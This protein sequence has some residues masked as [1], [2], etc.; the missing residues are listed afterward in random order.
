[1]PDLKRGEP[2]FKAR[3]TGASPDLPYEPTGNALLDAVGPGAYALRK[4]VA[5]LDLHGQPVLRP[6]RAMKDYGVSDKDPDPRGMTVTGAD[7]KSGG[8][9]VDVWVDTVEALFR[10]LEVETP[11]QGGIRRVLLPIPFA[12]IRRSGIEV[13]AITGAQFA[14]VPGTKSADQV[15]K[16]EE[17][18]I[19]AFYGGGMLY[20][21]PKRAEP[22]L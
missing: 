10:Y 9:V 15:T 16:L 13:N 18:R 20:A 22:I 14:H 17:D 7:G 1:V 12:R 6:L 8:K 11:A 3:K 19:S 4:D 5:D 21:D 2:E